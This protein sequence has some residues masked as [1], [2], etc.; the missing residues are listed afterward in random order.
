MTKGVSNKPPT[1]MVKAL[2]KAAQ[3]PP[4]GICETTPKQPRSRKEIEKKATLLGLRKI[5]APA[6]PI[7]KLAEKM[8]HLTAC[9]KHTECHH[10]CFHFV[11]FPRS[12]NADSG[13]TNHL[14][15]ICISV[16]PL[17]GFPR[18]V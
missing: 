8:V 4:P 6:V 15:T 12:S 5:G 16:P 11:L 10:H 9:K 7:S 18:Y 17:F 13:F 3:M 2:A 1:K 14:S